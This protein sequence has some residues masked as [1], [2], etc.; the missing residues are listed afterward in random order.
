MTQHQYWGTLSTSYAISV[1]FTLKKQLMLRS[2][3]R[4]TKKRPSVKKYDCSPQK[5]INAPQPNIRVWCIHGCS[6]PTHVHD[7]QQEDEACAMLFLHLDIYLCNRN[8]QKVWI[9]LTYQSACSKWNS[10]LSSVP[11]SKA[12]SPFQYTCSIFSL[13]LLTMQHIGVHTRLRTR[14]YTPKIHEHER[15]HTHTSTFQI[16]SSKSSCTHVHQCFLVRCTIS[17]DMKT[18]VSDIWNRFEIKL[19]GVS[20]SPCVKRFCG[21][22][23]PQIPKIS[24]HF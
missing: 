9:K 6:N 14:T 20:M 12:N 4:L 21:P 13:W 8:K 15:T 1:S 18:W 3:T 5:A 19:L 7:K 16:P 10:T 23:T 2:P 24:E 17:V 22:H 11:Q